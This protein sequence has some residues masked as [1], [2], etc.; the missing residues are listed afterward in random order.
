MKH[1]KTLT[2]PQ[3]NHATYILTKHTNMFAKFEVKT[4]IN[5]YQ[6]SKVCG[7]LKGDSHIACRAHAVPLPCH[8]TP[9]SCSDSAVSFVKVRVVAGNIQTA[10]PT[11]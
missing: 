2:Q 4:L 6:Y 10:S 8:A 3:I 1:Q 5:V 11:V 9:L 7:Y